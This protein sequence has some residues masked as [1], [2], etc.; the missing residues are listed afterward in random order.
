MEEHGFAGRGLP[1]SSRRPG[2]YDCPCAHFALLFLSRLN[3]LAL[4]RRSAVKECEADMVEL[5]AATRV[6]KAVDCTMVASDMGV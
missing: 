4:L 3:S 1:S 5:G 6:P 2:P